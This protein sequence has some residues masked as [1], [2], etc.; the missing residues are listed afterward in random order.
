MKLFRFDRTIS[1]EITAHG[2]SGLFMR[3]ILR[4]ARNVRVDVMHIEPNGLVGGHHANDNQ[5]FAVVQGDGWVRVA[6]GEPQHIEK[7]QA[8]FWTQGEWHESGT[9]QG[10]TVIVIEGPDLDPDGTMLEISPR[11]ATE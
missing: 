8:A 1:G 2:S 11:E 10:M 5:L 6:D 4:A 7:H 3:R 9:Q